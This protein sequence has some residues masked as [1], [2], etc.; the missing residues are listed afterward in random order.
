MRTKHL[1]PVLLALLLCRG[2]AQ[3]L[4]TTG[5]VDSRLGKLELENNPFFPRLWSS[6]ELSQRPSPQKQIPSN[7]RN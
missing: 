2:L 6:H 1:V 4:P 7:L 5:T 3:Q